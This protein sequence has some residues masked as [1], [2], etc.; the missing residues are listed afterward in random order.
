MART[1]AKR[2]EIK[3]KK[4]VDQTRSLVALMEE[5]EGKQTMR[6]LATVA[7]HAAT[8]VGKVL[9]EQQKEFAKGLARGENV[10]SAA[11]RAGYGEDFVR[12]TAYQVRHQPAFAA[13]VQKLQEE[14]ESAAQMTRKKFMDMLQE[15]YD[16]AKLLSEPASMV[17]AAR[18]IGKACGYYAPTQVAVTHGGNVVLERMN[19]LS[20][21][22]L[23]KILETKQPE[24]E[25]AV[26][27]AE[28]H[29][30]DADPR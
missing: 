30:T 25:H 20:D 21:A 26:E 8:S 6:R 4:H 7:D 1:A 23:L 14:Y 24:I 11:R 28:D 13:Y 16:T 22:E 5:R 19:K 12:K 2:A 27:Q 15:S 17:A 29:I 18:E 10:S 9:T 3:G